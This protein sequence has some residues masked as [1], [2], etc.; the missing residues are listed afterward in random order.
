MSYGRDN[1]LNRY[2]YLGSP[3]PRRPNDE[4]V[5]WR[6][7]VEPITFG[8]SRGIYSEPF[9]LELSANTPEAEI[10]YTIDGSVPNENDGQ[11][12]TEPILIDQT[13]LLQAVGFKQ[14]YLPS[15]IDTHT[16]IF[17]DNV[18]QQLANPPGFPTEWGIHQTLIPEYHHLSG[19]PVQAD[20]EMDPEIVKAQPFREK[21]KGAL[22]SIPTLSIITDVENFDIYLNPRQRGL[23]W[24]RPVS[25]ELIYPNNPTQNIQINAGLRIQGGR[26]REE[27]IPKH[28]FRLFFREEYGAAKFDHAQFPNSTMHSFDTLVLKAGTNRSYAG[29]SQYSLDDPD[30]YAATTYTRDEWARQSQIVMSGIGAHGTFVHLYLNGL[31]WGLYNLIE[32]PDASFAAAYLGDKKADWYAHNHSGYVSGSPNRGKALQQAIDKADEGGAPYE[33]IQAQVD[34]AHLSD[35]MLLNWYMGNNDAENNWYALTRNSGGPFLFFM[36]DAEITWSEGAQIILK[37]NE[38]TGFVDRLFVGLIKHPE[39]RMEFAD[40]AYRHLFNDGALTEAKA[41]ARWKQI[42]NFIEQA[43]LGESARWGD[44]R[45]DR[46]LTIADWRQARDD[47][48]AQMKG[49]GIKLVRLMREA[50]YYPAL[51]PPTFNQHGGLISPGFRLTMTPS[52]HPAPN[53]VI[54]YTTDG[55]DPRLP[56]SGAVAPAAL[57]YSGPLTLNATTHLKARLRA[58]DE[59]SALNEAIFSSPGE[60]RQVVITEIMYNPP[61]GSAYEFIE[62]QNIAAEPVNLSHMSFEGIDFTFPANS[63]IAPGAFVIL[64]RD[65]ENFNERYPNVEIDG[66]YSGKLANQGEQITLKTAEGEIMTSISYNDE[67]GWPLTPDGRGDSLVLIDV[68]KEP[69]DPKNWRA[70]LELYGSPGGAS[71][72]P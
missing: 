3:T 67:K 65:P 4:T 37:S 21:L 50:G 61:D 44:V 5:T 60:Q 25:V 70:S 15:Q 69:N 11:R 47:V 54:Y 66:V 16:Y 2:Q 57:V 51:D 41:Q 35:Y 52:D 42:N 58:G 40:R 1:N 18:L 72:G 39:F 38:T 20:Y 19:S 13:T 45:S 56:R 9:R 26:G 23:A 68:E 59:W 29:Y 12:Y 33:V 49:N 32:R 71:E 17:L 55:S 7:V 46:P 53:G 34:T 24:E 8:L 28:S 14:N 6:G 30:W 31:Y 36:W 62:L 64:V 22:K 63:T 10:Y 43:M 48:L 27:F